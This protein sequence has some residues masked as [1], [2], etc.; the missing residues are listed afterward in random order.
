MPD[1]RLDFEMLNFGKEDERAEA[2]SFNYLRFNLTYRRGM[3]HGFSRQ[4]MSVPRLVLGDSTHGGHFERTFPKP[5]AEKI[6]TN[7]FFCPRPFCASVLSK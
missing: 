3:R 7:V 2:F 5:R 1:Q 6:V 4:T